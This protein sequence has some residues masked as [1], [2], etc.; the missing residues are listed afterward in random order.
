M[1]VHKD[2]LAFTV[3]DRVYRVAQGQRLIMMFGFD[4]HSHT[5]HVMYWRQVALG[6]CPSTASADAV[7]FNPAEDIDFEVIS[8]LDVE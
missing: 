1:D 2:F 3:I 6:V 7:L 5:P 8:T 4:I